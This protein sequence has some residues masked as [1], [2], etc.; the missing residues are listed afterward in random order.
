MKNVT[1]YDLLVEK[2]QNDLIQSLKEFCAIDSVYDENTV[3]DEN[4]F[5]KGV[6]KALDYITELA[7]KDGFIATNYDNMVVEILA[8]KG[9]KNITILAHADVVPVGTGWDQDPF[10]VVEKDGVLTGRGVADDK[11]PLLATYYALKALRDNNLLGD[12]LVR[13]IVGGNEESG[14]RGVEKYFHELKKEQPTLGFSPD[15]EFPLIFAEKGIFN[16]HV[17]KEIKLDEVISIKGGVASNSVIERC[18]V[19]VKNFND[20]VTYLSNN[21]YDFSLEGETIVFNGKAAHGS[22]PQL[23]V[24][25][26]MLALKAISEFYK[27]QDFT[28]IVEQYSDVYGRGINAYNYS[29]EMGENSLNVG[30]LSYEN[31]KF[32]MVVNFRHVDVTT[33]EE[34][35]KKITEETKP[36]EIEVGG[37]SPLLYYPKDSALVSALLKAYQEETDDYENKPKAIGGGTY[38]KEAENVVAF[39]MEFA[40]WD[41]KM[42]SPGEGCK[43]SDLFK[44]MSVYARA[45]VELGKV[46]NEN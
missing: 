19:V 32:D 46:L 16:F 30:L 37:I 6:S 9:K 31:D 14:S 42:H 13:F 10:E 5:G 25:S 15:A 36:F 21:K 1:Q 38:A 33:P 2:Y 24:N 3:D 44:G 35:I 43:K 40:G 7:R 20:F 45:I 12:Y 22:T 34:L 17:R 29:E 27:S 11:G 28:Q 39:G 4:P 26:G 8:G 18:E 23:G 41:S